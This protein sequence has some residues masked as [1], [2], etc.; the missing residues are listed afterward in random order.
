MEIK[1]TTTRYIKH[2]RLS[3][4]YDSYPMRLTYSGITWQM[5]RKQG[6]IKYLENNTLIMKAIATLFLTLTV[7]FSTYAQNQNTT[8]SRLKTEQPI[9]IVNDTIIG[10]MDLLDTIPSD[11]VLDL[12]IFEDRRLSTTYLFVQHKKHAG[13]VTASINREFKF[14]TQKELNV[15]FGLSENN[16][17]YVNGHLIENKNQNIASES[18]VGIELVKADNFR[19]TIPVLNIEIE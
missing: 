17:V 4:G 13:V 7:G 6:I 14:K 8:I 2:N 11:N 3:A 12:N 15:F 1:Q 18:I 16:D 10:S 5:L 9:L 19:T